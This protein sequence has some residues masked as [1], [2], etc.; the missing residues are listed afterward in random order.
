M[1]IRAPLAACGSNR[2]H[3]GLDTDHVVRAD[4]EFGFGNGW[5]SLI[6]KSQTWLTQWPIAGLSFCE[7]EKLLPL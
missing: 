7:A 2:C 5:N 1:T 3:L 6:G 4:T